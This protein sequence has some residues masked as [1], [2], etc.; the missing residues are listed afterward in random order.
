MGVK[1]SVAVVEGEDDVFAGELA[2]F[3]QL[4]CVVEVN[5]FV[6]FLGEERHLLGEPPGAG[7]DLIVRAEI[8]FWFAGD[9]VVHE[10]RNAPGIG[11]GRNLA[12]GIGEIKGG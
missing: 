4:E 11:Q 9:A 12:D 1:I 7:I 2:I 6:S 10:D 8:W 5:D 3:E